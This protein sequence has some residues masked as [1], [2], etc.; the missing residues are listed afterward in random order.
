MLRMTSLDEVPQL[1]NVLRGEMTLVGP[2]PETVALALRYPAEYRG[3]FAYR[4]GLTGPVHVQL[5]DAVPGDVDDVEAFYIAELLPYRVEIDL[6]YLR[7]PSLAATVNLIWQT[8]AYVLSRALT[9]ALSR[10]RR[11]AAASAV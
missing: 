3:I 4:P 8:V 11:R 7:E 1:V 9:R 5:Q 10:S 2:R 6:G